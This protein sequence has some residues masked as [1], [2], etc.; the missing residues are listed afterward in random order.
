MEHINNL[1]EA[2]INYLFQLKEEKEKALKSVPDGFLRICRRGKKTQ[3]Y[4]RTDPKDFNGVY[5]REKNAELARKLAQKDYDQKVLCSID[6]E[7][8]AIEKYISYG[9]TMYVEQIYESL[10]KER[11]KLIQPIVESKEQYIHN[12]ENVKYKGKEFEELTPEIYTA[13]GGRVR[14]KSEVIIADL[15]N[16]EGIPYRY[17]YPIYLK[18]WGKVYPDFTVLNV[19]KRKELYWEHFGM[20]DDPN[21]VESALEKITLYEK[22]GIF[23]G[24]NL[25]LT[26]ETK[27]NPVNQKIVGLMIKQY[28]K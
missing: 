24:G 28:L 16:R 19:R 4:H 3:Y 21:Y 2:R 1:L 14:S 20:M 5:I 25:I 13:K 8:I 22:N 15:L 27:K 11:Q 9:P 18:G 26:F 12:W 7:L 17:E 6:K 23:P 10:H